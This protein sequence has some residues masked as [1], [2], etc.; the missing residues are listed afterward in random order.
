MVCLQALI[1]TNTEPH[2]GTVEALIAFIDERLYGRLYRFFF[3]K[4][5]HSYT[6]HKRVVFLLVLN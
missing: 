2:F 3:N 4:D 6:Q 1:T 5:F